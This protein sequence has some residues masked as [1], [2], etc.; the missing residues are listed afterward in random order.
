MNVLVVFLTGYKES[1]EFSEIVPCY[2]M[3]PS[4]ITTEKGESLFNIDDKKI[5][6]NALPYFPIRL[7]LLILFCAVPQA[8]T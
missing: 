7:F 1:F 4:K 5:V 2:Y 6:Q 3:F 8:V